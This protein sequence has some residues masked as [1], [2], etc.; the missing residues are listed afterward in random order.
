MLF[1]F[2]TSGDT[3]KHTCTARR[4]GVWVVFSCPLC[5]GFERRMNI[6]TGVMRVK[7][8]AHPQVLHQGSFTPVGLENS[9]SLLN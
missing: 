5:P 2:D 1:N 8:G 7:P 4:D 6:Q 3:P 9:Y